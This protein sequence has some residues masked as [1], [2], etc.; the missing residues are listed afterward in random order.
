ME[1]KTPYQ[2]DSLQR[3]GMAL[4][5][6]YMSFRIAIVQEFTKHAAMVKQI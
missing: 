3:Q 5:Q 4:Q 1:E 2:P 6:K